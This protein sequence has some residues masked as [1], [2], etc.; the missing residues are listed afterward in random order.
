MDAAIGSSGTRNLDA[1]GEKPRE[2]GFQD[3]GDGTRRRLPLKAAKLGSVVL[4][5][6]AKLG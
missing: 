3:A 1:L 4:N 2:R 5:G 6:Q